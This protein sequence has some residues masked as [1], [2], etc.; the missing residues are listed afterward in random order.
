MARGTVQFDPTSQQF[1][2]GA[3]DNTV[4]QQMADFMA[5]PLNLPSSGGLSQGNQSLP[6]YAANVI[7]TASTSAS[8]TNV[9]LNYQ[10]SLVQNLNYQQGQVS[11]VNLDQELSDL[12]TYQQSYSAA[13]KVIS[14]MQQ[15]FQ[16]LNSIVQ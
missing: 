10:G 5:S 1:F 13:A 3:S 15:L 7:A 14:T 8:N 16:V 6:Q 12:L 4:T 2:V 11:G 9:Q